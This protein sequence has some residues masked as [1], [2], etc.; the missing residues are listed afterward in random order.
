MECNLVRSH[1]HDFKIKR[2]RSTSS[3]WDHKYDFRPKL[4]DLK[5][6]CHF[7]TV[8]LKCKLPPS[9]EERDSYREKRDS[10]REKR[11]LYHEKRD[12]YCEK[13]N[14]YREKRDSYRE[15]RDSPS[16]KRELSREK[17]L[18]SPECTASTASTCIS[19]VIRRK[20][21]RMWRKSLSGH[22][23]YRWF[24]LWDKHQRRA[25]GV[26]YSLAL[27]AQFLFYMYWSAFVFSLRL[28]Y[29]KDEISR[30]IATCTCR[31]ILKPHNLIPKFAKQWLLCVSFPCNAIG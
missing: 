14:S 24:F 5:F 26:Q 6:S 20:D 22:K 10:Y 29:S 9:H 31:S 13:R 2:V 15:K 21:C 4:H 25:T 11:D 27:S 16:R 18:V 1:T 30:W 3:I 19:T 17:F 12:S 7:T 23:S 28:S 8:P